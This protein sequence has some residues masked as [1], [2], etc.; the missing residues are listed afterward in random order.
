MNSHANLIQTK[1]AA[2]FLHVNTNDNRPKV[3]NSLGIE[4]WA[5]HKDKALEEPYH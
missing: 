5:T 3:I 4:T 1:L 2:G